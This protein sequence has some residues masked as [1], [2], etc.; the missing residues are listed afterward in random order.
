VTPNAERHYHQLL[1]GVIEDVLR[2][3]SGPIRVPRLASAAGLSRFH[4]VRLFSRMTGETLEQFLRRLRLERAAFSLITTTNS[5]LEISID[6]GYQ[7]PEAFSRSFRKAFG[8]V[9]TE[10]RKSAK[11]WKLE[12]PVNLHWNVDWVVIDSTNRTWEESPSLIS[13]KHACVWRFVGNYG[14]LEHGWIRCVER[15][16]TQLP[17]NATFVTCYLDNMWTH[18]VR[19]TMRADIGWICNPD[20]IPPK[21]MRKIL[22]PSGCYVS[23]RF[24]SRSE[25][26]D[27]WSY[28]AG[29]YGRPDNNRVSRDAYDIYDRLPVPFCEAKTKIVLGRWEADHLLEISRTD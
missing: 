9:P 17:L 6:C 16:G 28:I 4:L 10:F 18:P 12:S 25:R 26:N 21:G 20:F 24:V 29:R 11:D 23:S 7:S 14:W 27:A 13:A 22:I 5:V 15:F 1:A 19:D 8:A 3:R 2:C